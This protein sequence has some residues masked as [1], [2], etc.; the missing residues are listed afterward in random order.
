MDA[1]KDA[2]KTAF[3]YGKNGC[4]LPLADFNFGLEKF[5]QPLT[6]LPSGCF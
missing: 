3:L 4:M 1:L 2:T 6:G 5:L